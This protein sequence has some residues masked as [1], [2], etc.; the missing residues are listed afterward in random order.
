L[1]RAAGE[2]ELA[3]SVGRAAARRIQAHY[4]A[5]SPQLN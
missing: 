1:V 4:A 2:E 3:A 5:L